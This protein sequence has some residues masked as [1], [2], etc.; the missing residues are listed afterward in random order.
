MT[1]QQISLARSLSLFLSFS[2]SLCHRN[3]HT[4]NNIPDIHEIL[5]LRPNFKSPVLRPHF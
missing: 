1:L 5:T 3:T 4:Q 2:F